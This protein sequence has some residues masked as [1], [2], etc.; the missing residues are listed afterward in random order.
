MSFENG[1]FSLTIYELPPKTADDLLEFF[2][3]HKAGML[4]HVKDEPQIG[5]VCGR[6]LLETEINE[7][8]AMFGG[9]VYVSMRKAE[10]K[11]PPSLMNAICRRDELAYLRANNA[12]MV[13]SRVRRDIKNEVLEKHLMKMPPGIT[14]IPLVIDST[15]N[16]AYVGTTS[17]AQLDLLVAL[18]YKSTEIELLRLNPEFMIENVLASTEDSFPELLLSDIPDGSAPGRD[19]LTWLWYYSEADGGLMEHEQF[20]EFAIM[21]EGPLT[22]AFNAET[23]G[24]AETTIKKG[25][26]PLRSA[27]AKAALTV[28]KKL[29]KAKFVLAR[30]NEMW[31]GMFDADSFNFGSLSMPEGEE[32]EPE[33]RFAERIQNL[34]IFQAIFRNYFQKYAETV[35]A[36]N[37]PET[38]KRMRQWAMERD[39]Y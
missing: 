39:S 13:P 18:F 20:G 26:S 6:S 14:G 28:G 25:G 31:S 12:V 30:G 21:I 22:F 37:W 9:H 1:S 23:R 10:R 38:Q 3:R 33:S 5:W 8:S 7:S 36:M 35:C 16:L 17:A 19:F 4:D 15:A 11:I 27:E 32:M 29:K 2:A 34:F 24:A